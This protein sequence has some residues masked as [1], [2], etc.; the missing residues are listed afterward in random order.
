MNIRVLSSHFFFLRFPR[1][2]SSMPAV[3]RHPDIFVIPKRS[4]NHI[5][6]LYDIYHE[7]S[8][9]QYL[10]RF[11]KDSKRKEINYNMQIIDIL[12]QQLLKI[13][14]ANMHHPISCASQIQPQQKRDYR[15]TPR[16]KEGSN[17]FT[18]ISFQCIYQQEMDSK[19]NT[20]KSQQ[21]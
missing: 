7:T 14:E 6:Q 17:I 11:N 15:I 21:F 5:G 16:T 4:L 12:H 9:S 13:A 8:H 18:E 20:V 19:H 3:Y 2:F 10:D 1:R